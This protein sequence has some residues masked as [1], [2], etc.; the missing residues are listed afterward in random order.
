MILEGANFLKMIKSGDVQ[1]KNPDADGT[2]ADT[3]E[4]AP[5]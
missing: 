3:D 5:F 2:V 4:S 1:A